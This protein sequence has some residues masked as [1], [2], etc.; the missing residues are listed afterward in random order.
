MN[1]TKFKSFFPT[2]LTSE[3]LEDSMLDLFLINQGQKIYGYEARSLEHGWELRVP[4]PGAS[5]DDINVEVKGTDRLIVEAE[6]ESV[7]G[8]KQSRNFKIPS[9]SD[10]DN[11]EGEMS[12]GILTLTIPKKK[13][14]K[15]KTIKIK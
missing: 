14:F 10:V 13:S 7:W 6:G 15:E 11:I 9:D 4:F 8:K 12:N 2:L 5:K 1:T 3:S